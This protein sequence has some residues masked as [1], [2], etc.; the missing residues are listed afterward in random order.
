MRTLDGRVAVVTGAASGIGLAV[1]EAFVQH[2]VKVVMS[3]I[4]GD[5]LD[6]EVGRLRAGGGDVVAL[7]ADVRDPD[8]VERLATRTVEQF[9]SLNIAVN[10]AGVVNMKPSWEL[11][12]DEW[13]Q[14]LDVN[15]YGVIH[16][17]RSFV[18]RILAAGVEGHVINIGSRAS[19]TA[20]PN[21][22]P[23]TV[24][25]HGV[26]AISDVLRAEMR[27]I[28]AP[29]GV[30]VVMPGRINTRLNPIGRIP[31]SQVALNIIDAMLGDRPYVFTDHDGDGDVTT[32]LDEIRAALGQV[33]E[34]D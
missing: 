8:A 15:L 4:D 29:V 3:D 24:A 2:G 25:K 12:L 7:V 28:G 9:G 32:R 13:N 11:T 21:L 33:V 34:T 19:V 10:N 23:Y 14:V 31:A 16:G 17:I 1:A 20:I 18:P 22:A 5:L 30:S 6:T 26:L 27:Q